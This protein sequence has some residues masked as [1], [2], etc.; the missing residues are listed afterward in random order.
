[1]AS[2][3]ECRCCRA[4]SLATRWPVSVSTPEK[5]CCFERG[6]LSDC[7]LKTRTPPRNPERS[8]AGNPSR[9][10]ARRGTGPLASERPCGPLPPLGAASC[11]LAVDWPSTAPA[12]RCCRCGVLAGRDTECLRLPAAW[13]CPH[14][15]PAPTARACGRVCCCCVPRSTRPP[16]RCSLPPPL[17]AATRWRRTRAAP[18]ARLQTTGWAGGKK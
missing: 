2:V 13:P 5:T 3:A 11:G 8:G 15:P 14:P 9:R 7:V 6:L 16:A 12:P 10:R 4:S 1:M 18:A 17:P